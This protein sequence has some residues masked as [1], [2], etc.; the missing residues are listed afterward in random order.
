MTQPSDS[1]ASFRSP[2]LMNADDSALMVI[3]LQEKLVPH[4]SNHAQIVWNISRLI[5]GAGAL[6]VAVCGTEQYPKGLGGTVEPIASLLQA[7]S[8]QG[9]PEKTMFSCRECDSLVDGLSETGIHNL[10][11]CGIETHVCV[12]QSAL[13]LMAQGFNVFVCVDAIGARSPV[14]HRVAIRRL[15]NSGVTLTTTEAA[16]FEWCEQAGSEK[17]KKISK[18]VQQTGP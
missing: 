3:D 12:A 14:D 13:D 9:V 10:L 18:L 6:G 16:L 5:E 7:N 8:Q 17:F 2:L 11:L 1:T 4:I 15:E